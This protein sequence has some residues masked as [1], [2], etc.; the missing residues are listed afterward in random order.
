M[1]K[2]RH[3]YGIDVPYEKQGYIYFKSL[4]Y[5]IL[6]IREQERIRALCARVGGYNG[7]ALLEH[8]TTGEPVKDVCKRHF[9]AST[10]TLYRAIKRYYEKFPEDL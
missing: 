3:K 9:I 10:T 7:D 2:F 1:P 6:P 5:N 4:R 8:V